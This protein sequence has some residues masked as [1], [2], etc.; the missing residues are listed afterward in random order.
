[1]GILEREGVEAISSE[2]SKT[3]SPAGGASSAPLVPCS[4]VASVPLCQHP[5]LSL[6]LGREWLDVT[7]H[8]DR[9]WR[10]FGSQLLKDGMCVLKNNQANSR[11]G[12]G[13]RRALTAERGIDS[14]FVGSSI[15]VTLRAGQARTR[16]SGAPSGIISTRPEHSGLSLRKLSPLPLQGLP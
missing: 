4:L 16:E 3:S 14:I 7:L 2:S 5:C 15:P 13:S 12:Q 1:M 10:S 11:P 6:S 8:G 9:H